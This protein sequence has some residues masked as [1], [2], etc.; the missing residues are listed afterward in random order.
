MICLDCNFSYC[1]RLRIEKTTQIS[2]LGQLL[3]VLGTAAHLRKKGHF[4]FLSFDKH[5]VFFFSSYNESCC[6][7]EFGKGGSSPVCSSFHKTAVFSEHER[8]RHA[9]GKIITRLHF[10]SAYCC[11]AMSWPHHLLCLWCTS[12]ELCQTLRCMRRTTCIYCICI[13]IFYFF[14]K[15][16]GINMQIFSSLRSISSVSFLF[17]MQTIL[18]FM[19]INILWGR[20][21]FE[22]FIFFERM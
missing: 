15:S 17:Q 21:C 7:C 5:Q 10:I 19:Q 18:N 6:W 9:Q 8:G 1:G 2:V 11:K 16:Q 13:Y 3:L 4:C 14:F 22:H 20:F 12:S